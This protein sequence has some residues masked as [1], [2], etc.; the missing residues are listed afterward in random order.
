[1]KTTGASELR[2]GGRLLVEAL[3]THGVETVFGV[4]GESFLPALDAFCDHRNDIRFVNCRHEGGAAFMADAYGKLTGRPGICFVSRGPG[5]TN[6]SIGVHTAFQDST[7]MILFIG[8]VTA[9]EAEREA[10]QEIDYRRM[11]GPLAKWVA[12]IDRADRIQ[13]MVSHAFH[14][15]MSGRCGPVVL[16]LPEDMLETAAAAASAGCYQRVQAHAGDADLETM[17]SMLGA[18]QRPLMLL[19]GGGW[20]A[21]AC[22][23]IQAFAEANDLPVACTYRCQDLFDNRHRNYV[24]DVSVGLNPALEQRIRDADLLLVV[25]ARMGGWTTVNFTLI[26][27]P[28]P[29]QKF[30][31][32]HAGAAELGSVYQGDLLIH[33][34]MREFAAATRRLAP[35]V[36]RWS[37]HT[38]AAREDY[39]QWQ[40][41]VAVPGE[42]NLSEIVHFLRR[43]LPP[44]TIV[45]C[46]AGAYIVWMHRFFQYTGFRTQLGPSSGCMGYGVPAAIAARLV[47]PDRPV[48]SFSGDGCFLMNGQEL[49]T[50]RHHGVKCLHIVVNNGIYGTI[51]MVQEKRYPG[52][53]VGTDLSNPD[54]AML[55]RAHGLHGEQVRTTGEFE[56]AF[57][58]A[59]QAES[60]ALIELTLDPDVISPRTTLSR[61]RAES[62]ME[63][64]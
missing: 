31:H 14:L 12:Q 49:A 51:R 26:D 13:E 2:P 9:D 44:E 64:D 15:A 40:K 48:V 36:I 43:R 32:V 29:R 56:Q 37:A 50:A 53:V 20:D 47:H 8:Q 6:A 46:G 42:L 5:A 25:G 7:P 30:I 41:P 61:L 3:L 19:G 18:A 21:G 10:F 63:N 24:G 54:F 59:W 23:D 57:E 38:R 55:A 33:S 4:P 27:I 58:R 62:R 34:G 39:A 45:T 28:R 1:M 11:Y 17:R 60:G 52:R 35:A 22:E 16:A